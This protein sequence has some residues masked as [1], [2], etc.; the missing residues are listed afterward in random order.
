MENKNGSFQV[1]RCDGFLRAITYRDESCVVRSADMCITRDPSMCDPITTPPEIHD[2]ILISWSGWSVEKFLA[3]FYYLITLV[4][5]V[6][7]QLEL[8]N[9]KNTQNIDDHIIGN[10]EQGPHQAANHNYEP[11]LKKRG[12][13]LTI[14]RVRFNS[15]IMGQGLNR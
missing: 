8:T 14:A 5:M 2:P 6:N 13:T 11:R 1:M 10:P 12:T 7:V 15:T 9:G 4:S 3:T